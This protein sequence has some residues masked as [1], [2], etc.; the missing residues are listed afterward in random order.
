MRSGLV[1][2]TGAG[3]LVGSHIVE[4]LAEQ[5]YKVRATDKPG[6][7]PS[8]AAKD[9]VEWVEA[10]LLDRDA[11]RR[12]CRGVRGAIHAARV[13]DLT[14]PWEELYEGNVLQ[15]EYLCNALIEANVDRFVQISSCSVYGLQQT[16]PVREDVE[17]IPRNDYEKTCGL[18]EEKVFHA[19]RF[20][21]L[22]AAVLRPALVYGPRGRTGLA[23]WFAMYALGQRH[24]YGWLRRLEGGPLGHHVHARDV[25]RAAMLLLQRVDAIGQAFHIGDAT[26]MTW[27][28]VTQYMANLSGLECPILELPRSLSRMV[29]VA[30][31]WVP[32]S[33]L[34]EINRQMARHWEEFV[35]TQNT[36]GHL[37]PRLD[38]DIFTYLG[39]DH[40]YDVSALTALGFSW[41]HPRT[42]AGLEET[43][44]WYQSE[45]WLPARR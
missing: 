14:L 43:F 38:R 12:V 34:A 28:E 45:R 3:D 39:A 8:W 33:R 21:G 1:L 22:P 32:S 31:Q 26:P 17:K 7:E 27:G 40:V 36:T 42:L 15:T 25:A 11:L 37:K 30:G 9:N 2:V 4:V 35:S 24:R 41:S 44:Q 10:D 18:A 20:R 29:S 19:Q 6:S 23:Q 16:V 13:D 5:G